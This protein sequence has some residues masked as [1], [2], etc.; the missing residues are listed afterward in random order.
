MKIYLTD[1]EVEQRFSSLTERERK[2]AFDLVAKHVELRERVGKP[3]TSAQIGQFELRHMRQAI[4]GR[5][6]L[7]TKGLTP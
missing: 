6:K 3:M 4:R 7:A 1:S 5:A 2:E